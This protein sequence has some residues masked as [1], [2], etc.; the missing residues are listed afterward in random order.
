MRIFCKRKSPIFLFFNRRIFFNALISAVA[1]ELFACER[2]QCQQLEY[3]PKV[4]YSYY[5]KLVP[6]LKAPLERS[7]KW[8]G[9]PEKRT[10]LR[11]LVKAALIKRRLKEQA[12]AIATT[13]SKAGDLELP[14]LIRHSPLQPLLDVFDTLSFQ[15]NEILP[16]SKLLDSYC[17]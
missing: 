13:G 3:T 15:L 2:Y 6:F 8:A 7:V 10:T 16:N 5:T 9:K 17:H 4:L 14:R 12:N 1:T 11:K